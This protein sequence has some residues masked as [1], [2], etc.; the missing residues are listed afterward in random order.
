M[1]HAAL[2]RKR[3]SYCQDAAQD[4]SI[5]SGIRRDALKSVSDWIVADA[6]E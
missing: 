3:W 4:P 6:A 2:A 5:A 1:T